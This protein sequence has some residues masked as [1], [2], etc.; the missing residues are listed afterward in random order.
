MREKTIISSFL[1]AFLLAVPAAA[2]TSGSSDAEAMTGE[3]A[4]QAYLTLYEAFAVA[5]ACRDLP[6]EGAG[7]NEQVTDVI[8]LKTNN[9]VPIGDQLSLIDDAKASAKSLLDKEG[10]EGPKAAQAMGVYDAQIAPHL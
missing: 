2:Q 7:L 8:S 3:Q 5:R 6:G 1:A 9:Q 4:E 10:C